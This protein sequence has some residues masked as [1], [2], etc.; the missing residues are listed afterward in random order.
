MDLKQFI[1]ELCTFPQ[2]TT[3]ERKALILKH[4]WN[5]S[6][7]CNDKD[8]DIVEIGCSYGQTSVVIKTF[9]DLFCPHKDFWVFDSFEGILGTSDKDSN[10]HGHCG[11]GDLS[12]S[13]DNFIKRFD[14]FDIC[15]PDKIS[16]V[17]VR[18]M[19]EDELPDKISFCYIDLDIYEPTKH[20]LPLIWNR[21]KE[22]G[23][24]VIDDYYYEEV[25][26][27]VKPAVDE[28]LEEN[29]IKLHAHT[30][31]DKMQNFL[32][33]YFN[34]RERA[35]YAIAISK[36]AKVDTKNL[37]KLW[38]TNVCRNFTMPEIKKGV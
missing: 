4:L 14:Q 35:G 9:I 12:S 29:L 26:N 5:T 33:E 19:K 8:G 10:A 2:M 21:L 37:E 1:Q 25:F 11:D 24:I 18:E 23:V 31:K 22:G 13:L 16:K 34:N 38:F 6:F 15:L 27:G 7:L 3:I 20:I 36:P 32:L 30:E 28:F 17:D